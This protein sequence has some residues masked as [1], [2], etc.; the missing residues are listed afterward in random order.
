METST[1]LRALDSGL[2]VTHTVFDD[3]KQLVLAQIY[4]TC[5]IQQSIILC[6]KVDMTVNFYTELETVQGV[7]GRGA[8]CGIYTSHKLRGIA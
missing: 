1:A 2:S 8:V 5:S 6:G 4:E 7:E 3:S